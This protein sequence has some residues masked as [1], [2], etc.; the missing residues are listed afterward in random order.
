MLH[1]DR[2][3]QRVVDGDIVH[4]LRKLRLGQH[5]ADADPAG[6]AGHRAAEDLQPVVARRGGPPGRPRVKVHSGRGVADGGEGARIPAGPDAD[7]LR[8]LVR[9]GEV[10]VLGAEGGPG[11]SLDLLQHPG[12][13]VGIGSGPGADRLPRPGQPDMRQADVDADQV[14]GRGQGRQNRPGDRLTEDQADH[15]QDRRPLD[16]ARD[17]P[18]TRPGPDRAGLAEGPPRRLR[19]GREIP[20]IS[21]VR[22]VRRPTGRR[23]V[24]VRFLRPRRRRPARA[25]R[26]K[27]SHEENQQAQHLGPP[28]VRWSCRTTRPPGNRGRALPAPPRTAS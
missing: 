23:G 22:P 19:L 20:G 18:A 25:V 14:Q 13:D 9:E 7:V 15:D 16:L 26:G 4:G 8:H 21:A 6:R 3:R 1:V 2:T 27:H 11:D 24:A 17:T 5:D 12:A 28:S 10:E